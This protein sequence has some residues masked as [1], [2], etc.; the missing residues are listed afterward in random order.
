MLAVDRNR[1][2]LVLYRN[3][4]RVWVKIIVDGNNVRCVACSVFN[5]GGRGC[6]VISR[7]ECPYQAIGFF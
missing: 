4:F 3:N 6:A 7:Q 1:N 5:Y 2:R